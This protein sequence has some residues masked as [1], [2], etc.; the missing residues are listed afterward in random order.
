MVPA[1]ARSRSFPAGPGEG[2]GTK[3]LGERRIAFVHERLAEGERATY[4]RSAFDAFLAPSCDAF[5]GG[6]VA[7]TCREV[8]LR[9]LRWAALRAGLSGLS[10]DGTEPGL[11]D[12]YLGVEPDLTGR[13]LDGVSYG[14][15]A[16]ACE[17]C[18]I[19]RSW[20][21]KRPSRWQVRASLEPALQP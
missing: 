3:E 5:L 13:V 9:P 18:I 1:A 7:E 10:G 14:F 12:A 21:R 15:P 19:L 17:E 16:A 6:E 4:V 11:V 8:G 2:P 20:L